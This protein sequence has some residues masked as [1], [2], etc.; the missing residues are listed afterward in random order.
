MGINIEKDLL[1]EINWL[2]GEALKH[3]A[4]M[5]ASCYKQ[6]ATPCV[7]VDCNW[8]GFYQMIRKK[9]TSAVNST[10]NVILLLKQIGFKVIL[11]TD[12]A[13]RYHAK[14]VSID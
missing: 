12:C 11:M 5:V 2:D 7:A 4:V 10:V 6:N 9:I 8:V 13:K 14:R 3:A 1:Y